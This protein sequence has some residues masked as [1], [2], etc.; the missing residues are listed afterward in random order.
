MGHCLLPP[1]PSKTQCGPGILKIEVAVNTW[2]K[3]IKMSI[4]VANFILVFDLD[5]IS[6]AVE[7]VGEI[8]ERERERES[9]FPSL[10]CEHY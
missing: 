9:L 4:V 2:I 3:Q 7:F 8:G 5:G 1:R 6:E 10:L